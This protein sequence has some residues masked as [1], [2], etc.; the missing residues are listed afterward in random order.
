M[1]RISVSP[2]VLTSL[3]WAGCSNPTDVVQSAA[4]PLSRPVPQGDGAVTR[5]ALAARPLALRV[6][7]AG[8]A[9]IGQTDA[10]QL[11][12]LDLQTH[13]FTAT[14]AVGQI[15]SDI[16]F[17][18]VSARAYVSNQFSHNVGIIDIATR[19]E[20]PSGSST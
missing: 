19:P 12:K 10:S 17:N 6:S 5:L 16:V 9:Y 3:L 20:R 2:I 18:P 14:V 1:K 7:P 15:P 4:Q 11:A 8:F 13:T